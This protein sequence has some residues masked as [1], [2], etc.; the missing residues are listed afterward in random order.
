VP[1]Y[2]WLVVVLGQNERCY[3]RLDAQR[4][5]FCS[6]MPDARARK[7][8]SID[9][10]ARF[11]R[12]GAPTVNLERNSSAIC[13][14]LRREDELMTELMNHKR[15][16]SQEFPSVVGNILSMNKLVVH[17]HNKH[18]YMASMNQLTKMAV[19]QSCNRFQISL[20]RYLGLSHQQLPYF[21]YTF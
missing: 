2:C 1:R 16:S 14:F 11:W 13:D 20:I 12:K 19:D 17:I 10:R 9:L 8:F 15:S 3:G 4:F 7:R 6:L 21:Y 18:I 5:C